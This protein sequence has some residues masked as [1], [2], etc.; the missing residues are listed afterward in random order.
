YASYLRIIKINSKFA[1]AIM[2]GAFYFQ[3][4]THEG[5]YITLIFRSPFLTRTGGC[6]HNSLP[7]C[8][9]PG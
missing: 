7:Q 3:V 8:V 4:K 1:P 6:C 5:L 9:Y 2:A